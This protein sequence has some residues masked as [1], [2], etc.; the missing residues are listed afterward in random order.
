M[1]LLLMVILGIAWGCMAFNISA[2]IWGGPLIIAYILSL[3]F[4]VRHG[5]RVA[6]ATDRVAGRS[7]ISP[8]NA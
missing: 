7:P 3:I 1:G 2:W 5:D 8:T 4:V 6:M